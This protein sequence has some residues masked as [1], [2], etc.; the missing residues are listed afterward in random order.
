M[1]HIERQLVIAVFDLAHFVQAVRGLGA[2]EVADLVDRYY[3]DV[4]GPVTAAG[5][6]IVKYFGDGILAVFP[7]DRAADAVATAQALTSVVAR[8]A[9]DVGLPLELGVNL[10]LT[11]VAEGTFGPNDAYDIMGPGVNFA[12]RL[13]VGAGVRIS[14]PVY[15]KLP[16]DARSAWDKYQPPATYTLSAR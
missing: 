14:E 7:P 12:F 13:G 5:G 1:A 8:L 6:R 16:S 9:A 4:D 3:R 2:S 11:V 15:R 10:H